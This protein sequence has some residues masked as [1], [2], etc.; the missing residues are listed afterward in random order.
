[1]KIITTLDNGYDRERE[2]PAKVRCTNCMT[3][4]YI[5]IPKGFKIKDYIQKEECP[6]CG[7][8]TMESAQ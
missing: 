4:Y 7:C 1:M 3:V 8:E 6:N 2:Y 5:A